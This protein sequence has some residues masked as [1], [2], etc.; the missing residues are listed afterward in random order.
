MKWRKSRISR[1]GFGY[2]GVR[3]RNRAVSQKKWLGFP[4]SKQVDKYRIKR[5]N[6]LKG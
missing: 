5:I 4:G 1:T 2:G 6:S 3:K